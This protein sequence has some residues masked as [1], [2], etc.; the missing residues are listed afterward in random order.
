MTNIRREIWNILDQAKPASRT[1]RIRQIERNLNALGLEAVGQAYLK[2]S[3]G[4]DSL[5]DLT[6]D[7]VETTLLYINK[8][9]KLMSDTEA[10]NSTLQ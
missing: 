1:S 2:Q 5:H 8:I 6:D 7:E 10:G 9:S 3:F 4:K